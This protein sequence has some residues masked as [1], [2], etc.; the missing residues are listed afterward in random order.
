MAPKLLDGCVIQ[1]REFSV[2]C[3][4]PDTKV[5]R[6]SELVSGILP[7]VPDT[8]ELVGEGVEMG[9]ELRR[10]EAR[11][12]DRP[13][14]ESIQHRFLLGGQV[15]SAPSQGRK[16]TIMRSSPLATQADLGLLQLARTPRWRLS[17][18]HND[19]LGITL[20]LARIEPLEDH[21]RS[22]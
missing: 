19:V 6:R 18:P 22:R 15:M 9:L 14:K 10:F 7:V 11:Q 13:F 21:C 16:R 12:N 5:S 17:T 2:T 1:L 8:M 20:V 4:R 3:L